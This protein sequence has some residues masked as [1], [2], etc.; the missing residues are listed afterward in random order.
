MLTNCL[1]CH[2]PL[3]YAADGIESCTVASCRFQLTTCTRG[4]ATYMYVDGVAAP[5]LIDVSDAYLPIG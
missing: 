2:G 3:T 1:H 5:G 4:R